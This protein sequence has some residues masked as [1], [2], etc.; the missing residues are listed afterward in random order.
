MTEEQMER[1]IES[2]L[3]QNTHFNEA[4]DRVREVVGQLSESH[5]RSV[6][7]MQEIR[8][9]QAQ[10]ANDMQLLTG[11][12]IE[13]TDNVS[14][15]EAQGETDRAE[16]REAI[17]NLIIANEVT[18]KLAEDV[19]RLVVQTN[20]RVTDLDQRVVDLESKQ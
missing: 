16:I 1:A 7:E 13:L 2:L 10:T 4:L 5:I 3:A 11:K 8:R 9:T 6:D 19:G 12:V 20:R 14:R 17:N 15:L 18:R